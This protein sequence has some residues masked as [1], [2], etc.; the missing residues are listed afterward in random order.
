MQDTHLWQQQ[1]EQAPQLLELILQWCAGQ[2]QTPLR[3]EPV[4]IPSQLALPVLHALRLIND[5]VLPLHLWK[6]DCMLTGCIHGHSAVKSSR[7]SEGPLYVLF[8]ECT[9]AALLLISDCED[10]A[11]K[12]VSGTFV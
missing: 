6:A 1:V 2:Q 7:M 3:D 4:Q 8:I 10:L 5:H 11:R 9:L 12:Y